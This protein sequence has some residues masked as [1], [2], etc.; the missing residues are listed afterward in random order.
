MPDNHHGLN[1]MSVNLTS[2]DVLG[3]AQHPALK[4]AMKAAVDAYGIGATGSRRLSGNHDIFCETEE[5]VAQ[6]VG[7]PSA[8]LFNSGYQMNSGVFSILVQK[9]TLVVADKWVHASIIDGLLR[10]P[11]T[12]KR[13]RHNDAAHCEAILEKMAAA[14]EA[15]I[16]VCESVYSMDGDSPPIHDL[17][18]LKH[19]Y[20]AMLVVDEAHAIGVFGADGRGWL[21]E[22]GVLEDVD[23]LLITFG[24]AMG[25]CGAMAL[26]SH[27]V[28][29]AIKR[30]CRSYI[31]ST[32][33]PLPVAAVIQAS[34]AIVNKADALRHQLQ[35][36]IQQFKALVHT[37]SNTH[38]QPIMVGA[39]DDAMA[40]QHALNRLGYEV[41][42]VH[43]PTVPKGQSRLRITISATHS[44]QD[45]Q[46]FSA[47]LTTQVAPYL[48]HVG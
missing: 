18:R 44:A 10:T 3:M 25:C 31:Y 15:V 5:R 11:A 35:A 26:G 34:V 37:E 6:W 19:A 17:V 43:H 42:A 16:I 7:K 23:V 12:V 33:L 30:Q 22:Q 1:Q 9:N 32:A 36:N 21:H 41:R 20:G 2:N 28:S 45:I 13:F 46:R 4:L 8:V 27:A 24:K 40:L 29:D 14:F 39:S 48:A 38:I 47:H